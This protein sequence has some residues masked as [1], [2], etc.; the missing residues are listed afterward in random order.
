M[1]RILVILCMTL[2]L[3][4]INA[5]AQSKIAHINLNDLRDSMPTLFDSLQEELGKYQA[6]L[7]RQL[8]G[9]EMEIKDLEKQIQTLENNVMRDDYEEI[10]LQLKINNYKSTVSAYQQTAQEFQNLLVEKQEEL[11]KPIKDQIEI[12]VK[13]IAESKGYDYVIDSSM[14]TMLYLAPEY[15]ILKEVLAALRKH[16]NM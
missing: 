8:K 12:T 2:G 5:N 15:D 11:L 14:G 13:A 1:K 3:G 7:E 6:K 4:A 10:Q 16:Y 9:F